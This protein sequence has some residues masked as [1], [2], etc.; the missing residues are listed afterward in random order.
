MPGAKME[1]LVFSR[2]YA[3]CQSTL[4]LVCISVCAAGLA[5]GQT[6]TG[7]ITGTVLDPS[8]AVVPNARVRVMGT[9]TGDVVRDL[10]TDASGAFTAPLLRPSGYMVEV[11]AQGFERLGRIGRWTVI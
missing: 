1:A 7:Q 2:G 9:E 5:V 4:R 10:T 8:G 3:M 6:S 11:I